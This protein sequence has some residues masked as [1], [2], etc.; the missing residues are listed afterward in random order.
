MVAGIDG[1]I[2]VFRVLNAR[3][4]ERRLEFC[5]KMNHLWSLI[6]LGLRKYRWKINVIQTR[7][8][9]ALNQRLKQFRVKLI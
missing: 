8:Y 9:S 6:L 3:K 5:V 7:Q 4:L 1:V 2:P